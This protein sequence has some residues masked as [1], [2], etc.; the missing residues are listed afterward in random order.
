M[1]DDTLQP[2]RTTKAKVTIM[3]TDLIILEELLTALERL[4]LTAHVDI[5]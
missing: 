5:N 4:H 3:V 1:R 2:R